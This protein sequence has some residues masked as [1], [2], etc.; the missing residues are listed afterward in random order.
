MD[1]FIV[2]C[3][4]RESLANHQCWYYTDERKARDKRAELLCSLPERYCVSI[5]KVEDSS[6]NV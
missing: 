2:E 4:V 6:T 3:Y 5:R 1:K